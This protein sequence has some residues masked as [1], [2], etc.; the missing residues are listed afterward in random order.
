MTYSRCSRRGKE[1]KL[2]CRYKTYFN[3]YLLS[4]PDFAMFHPYQ[5]ARRGGE[6]VLISPGQTSHFSLQLS[7][8]VLNLSA[9]LIFSWTFCFST[10]RCPRTSLRSAGAFPPCS[11]TTT[12]S[13]QPTTSFWSRVSKVGCV[14]EPRNVTCH[15]LKPQFLHHQLFVQLLQWLQRLLCKQDAHLTT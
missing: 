7:S 9:L 14:K 1:G 12:R 15:K 2:Y 11:P 13:R 8:F 6:V 3:V 10:G 5:I 4:S